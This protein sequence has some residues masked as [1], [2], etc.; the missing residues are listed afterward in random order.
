MTEQEEFEICEQYNKEYNEKI[1][2]REV[3]TTI[4]CPS[5]YGYGFHRFSRSM[6]SDKYEVICNICNGEQIKPD[7]FIRTCDE[8]NGSGG[9]VATM[10]DPPFLKCKKCK[11]QRYII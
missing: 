1:R 7:V 5:C 3:I 9:H 10:C 4:P 11:G 2:N 8:C 6:S